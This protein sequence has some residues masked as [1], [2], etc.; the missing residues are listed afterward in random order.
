MVDK[1]LEY[2]ERT[3]M[4]IIAPYVRGKKGTFK[5][6]LEKL[7]KDGFIRA[8]IDGEQY[9]LDEE[10]PELDKNKSHTI[11]VVIDRIIIKDGIVSRLQDSLETALQLGNGLVLVDVNGEEEL[12]F[13]ENYACPYCNFTVR[14]LEPRLFSF[15][16]PFGACD[17]CSGLGFKRKIDLNLLINDEN[18]SIYEG[19]IKGYEKTSSIYFKQL[20][21]TCEFYNIDIHKPF[22]DLTKKERDIVLYGSKDAIDFDFVSESN[23]RHQKTSYFEGVANNFER[24]YMETTSK[25]LRQWF[26]SMMTD[27][28]C[29]KCKGQRLS[30]EALS[31]HIGPYNIYQITEFPISKTKEILSRMELSEKRQKL[32]I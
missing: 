3:R 19:A 13:S 20:Q 1:L 16:S 6:D 11:D 22:K 27:Q 2:P 5:K 23:I 7:R 29:P 28:D 17:E 4:Q 15:N 21:Q 26:E 31:V 12:L 10:I 32:P 25:V 24:R 18:L 14:D 8:R 9:D 30:R